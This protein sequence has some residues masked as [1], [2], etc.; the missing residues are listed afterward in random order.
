MRPWSSSLAFLAISI[1]S[2]VLITAN[3]VGSQAPA[4]QDYPF[5]NPDLGIEQ[6]IVN[7]LS[8]LSLEEKIDCL[9]TNPSVP[10]LGIK[11]S[12]HVEGLHG[13]AEG[14]PADWGGKNTS[15]DTTQFPQAVGLGETWDP[16]MLQKAAAVEAN[17]ARYVF[18]SPKYRLSSAP[19]DRRG[20]VIRAPNADLARDPRWGRTEESYGEDP[21]LT[22]TMAVAFVKG[23]Q[24]SNTKYWEA[25]SLLKHFMANSNED[26]RGG[27]SS[28]FDQRLLREYYS[29]PFRMGIE[30][31]GARAFMTSYNAVNGIP[32]TASP[33][34]KQIVMKD[35]GFDGIIC[36]DAGALTNM[37]TQHR[38]YR[39]IDHAVAGAIHAGINQ[40]LDK[41]K[42]GIHEALQKNLITE[43]DIDENLRG[44]F[45]VMIH[46]GLLDPAAMVPYSTIAAENGQPEPW[47]AEDHRDVARQI[48]EKSI[49]LLKNTNHL[50]PLD[51]KTLHSIAI[52]G[53]LA[54]EVD[55]DW[56]SGTPPSPVTPLAGIKKLI[57]DSIT[58]NFAAN[59]DDGK[60]VTAA[61]ASD[62]AIVFVGNHPTCNAGWNHCPD[63]GEG[64]EAIDRKSLTL[65]P[66]Q[67]TLLEKVFAAN[68]RTVVVLV[69]SFPYAI[70]WI[71]QNIPAVVHMTHNSEEEGT[72]IAEA[73]FGVI[74]PGGRLVATWPSSTDQLPQMMDYN[75]RDG[76]TYM[77]FKG[78]PLFPFGYG[79]SY[80][81]FQYSNLRISA[82]QIRAGGEVTVSV[83]VRNASNRL[84]DEVVQMYVKHVDSHVSRPNEEL[85]GFRRITLRAGETRTVELPLRAEALAYW[86][87]AQNRWVVERDRIRVMVGG[88]SAEAKVERTLQIVAP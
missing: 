36:T 71:K 31:G 16:D 62:V 2:A 80:S 79:L 88:S 25:A 39:D 18:Q 66:A 78:E 26:G 44:V 1:V 7:I 73:L 4:Q 9:G 48:T 28:D 14:G 24:G 8:L 87:E 34:L 82:G 68:P 47:N 15:I 27:S 65:D 86:D 21:F 61:G 37:V 19:Y 67:E 32:M 58:V 20:I 54:D 53:P 42:D 75:L 59:D 22:G 69:S 72:A 50:L 23:L 84:G 30:I 3:A 70:S 83:D 63:P 5:R 33:I 40:F 64:K 45:R 41:Y 52:V 55:L 51:K 76:R 74:N 49:V 77:Y 6:R 13:L 17:E 56:Y 46:L 38:Y 29:V 10:R 85:K 35:W 57:G 60:A 81:T 43:K 12:G 11:G